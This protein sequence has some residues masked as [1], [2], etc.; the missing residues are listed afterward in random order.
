MKNETFRT[1]CR[2]WPRR[3]GPFFFAGG[4]G[5]WELN[6]WD[7]GEVRDELSHIADIGFD[8]VRLALPW[9]VL[10][11]SA[12][13]IRPALLNRLLL[14]LDAAEAAQLN[15]QLTLAGQ[16]SGTLFIPYW[17][18]A[19][20]PEMAFHTMQKRVITEDWV[21]PW[22]LGNFYQESSLLAGQRLFWR[23]MTRHFAAHP[24]LTEID[25]SAGGLLSVVPPR[26]PEEAFRWWEALSESASEEEII[27]LYSDSPALFMQSTNRVPRLH[28]WH[29]TVGQLAIATTIMD[30]NANGEE[31]LRAEVDQTW[32]LFQML[33]ART[34]AHAPVGSISLGVPTSQAGARYLDLE[35][36]YPAQEAKPHPIVLYAEEEQARFF[37]ETLPA[38]YNIGLPFICHTVWADAPPNLQPTPPYDQNIP[39]RHA[40][41]LRA[42][43]REKEAASIWRSFHAERANRAPPTSIRSLEI[44]EDEWYQRRHE[45]DFI[46]TLYQR[47][48]YGEI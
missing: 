47:Y 41:L 36:L 26:N 37:H 2:Y 35:E 23:E 24:A 31:A 7:V 48:R 39:L 22:P 45:V 8:F 21:S 34:L 4:F 38:L 19:T 6:L 14:L 16:L 30:G 29:G 20:K 28:E 11:P 18:L 40:G 44:D 9:E 27:L 32:P 12:T 10:Q 46:S 17:L 15:V 43:G 25:L 1:G 42:D 13:R 5:S 33:L 3:K